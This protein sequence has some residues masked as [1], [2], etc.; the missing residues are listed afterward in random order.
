MSAPA[1]DD[2]DPV[3]R[4]LASPVRRAFLDA[5]RES[6]RTTGDL[7]ELV[8]DLSRFAVMQHLDVLEKAQLITVVRRGRERFNFLN[9][10]PIRR[11]YERWVSR[12]EGHWSAALIALKEDLERSHPRQPRPA[13]RPRRPSRKPPRLAR[14]PL[15][16][17]SNP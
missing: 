1:R 2:L 4:A 17:E 16:P 5:L 10:V 13:A 11:I 14:D 8:P 7:A 9:A 6:P 3:W 12:Y 15:P